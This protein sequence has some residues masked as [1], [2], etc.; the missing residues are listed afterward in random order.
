MNSLNTSSFSQ[1]FSLVKSLNKRE[2]RLVRA[3]LSLRSNNEE[4]TRS[5]LFEILF[6]SKIEPVEDELL[7]MIKYRGSKSAMSHLRTRLVKDILNVTMLQ[8]AGKKLRSKAFV[9]SIE[10]KK[11]IVYT[12]LL[13]RRG[14][15]ELADELIQKSNTLCRKYELYSESVLLTDL[16][17]IR[18]GVRN[19]RNMVERLSKDITYS[20]Q[21][22]QSVARSVSLFYE[23]FSI[24]AFK[25]NIDA[26]KVDELGKRLK[27]FENLCREFPS[28]RNQYWFFRS[29]ILFH[30]RSANYQ[31]ALSYGYKLLNLVEESE[32]LHNPVTIAGTSQEMAEIAVIMHE[33]STA[34]ELSYKALSLF[35][36]RL[37]NALLTLE[38]LF[39]PTFHLGKWD[40]CKEL[41]GKAKAHP[42][43]LKNRRSPQWNYFEAWLEFR[44]LNFKRSSELLNSEVKA[45]VAD[46]G[47]LQ[48]GFRLL[49]ILLLHE[50]DKE[51]LIRFELDSFRQSFRLIQKYKLKRIKV[52]HSILSSLDKQLWN[53]RKVWKKE[54]EKIS[55]LK[56]NEELKWMPVGYEL[57]CF[58]KWLEYKSQNFN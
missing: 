52:I 15:T 40:A 34:I 53:F 4:K 55:S 47:D 38:V 5:T 30:S 50:N 57:V 25:P 10:V 33:Y 29:A 41:I 9:T 19:E 45:Y 6:K 48:I 16:Q 35:N 44:L 2:V 3:I 14:L 22:A 32:S 43:F 27:D 58:E 56:V 23:H 31:S 7:K 36:P 18:H 51:E 1:L 13:Y 46:K 39:F 11:T 8:E 42:L 12:E 21:M 54:K 26:G 28:N 17:R 37:G 24:L 20:L 49:T